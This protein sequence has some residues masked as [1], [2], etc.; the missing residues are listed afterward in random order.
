MHLMTLTLLHT[1]CVAGAKI[2][3]ITYVMQTALS[4]FF[5]PLL[6]RLIGPRKA[7]I[8]GDCLYIVYVVVN[9]FSS[10][11]R[12]ERCQI[13]VCIVFKVKKSAV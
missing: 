8:L 13:T 10:K 11:T 4:L 1:I 12:A 6:L 2:T 5:T 9:A 7:L 3:T